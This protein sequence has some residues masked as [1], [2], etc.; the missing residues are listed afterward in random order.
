MIR[1]LLILCLFL[2]LSAQALD[3]PQN[4][5][6]V[7][8]RAGLLSEPVRLKLEQFLRQFEETDSTQIVLLTIQ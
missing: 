4:S 6:Y 7:N 8:D 5:G 3:P 1:L 2:P